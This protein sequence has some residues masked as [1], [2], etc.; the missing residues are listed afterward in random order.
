MNDIRAIEAIRS[1]D[2]IYDVERSNDRFLHGEIKSARTRND[3]QEH[4][5]DEREPLLVLVGT[6]T[7]SWLAEK[8]R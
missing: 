7:V 8:T 6:A 2:R 1:N 3:D 5:A 4:T